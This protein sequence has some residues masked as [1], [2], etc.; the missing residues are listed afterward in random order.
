MVKIFRMLGNVFSYA[1]SRASMKQDLFMETA[2][3]S[4]PWNEIL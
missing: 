4:R 3:I 1:L 2:L